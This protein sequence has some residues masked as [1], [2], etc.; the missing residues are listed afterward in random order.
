MT[1]ESLLPSV[2]LWSSPAIKRFRNEL[3][4]LFEDF[5]ADFNW[6]M[7]VFEDLQPKAGFPKINVSE[8]DDDY[9]LEIAVAG[10]DKDDVKLELKDGVLT[11][12]ADKKEEKEEK[13]E[14]RN[15]LRKEISSRSF[16]RVVK[17]PCKV[18]SDKVEAEYTNGVITATLPK[19]K[20]DDSC[21]VSIKV[22]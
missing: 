7:A 6:P 11:I 22:K 3:D 9:K 17:F 20:K 5:F 16:S 4:S 19:D 15:Y 21:G 10:F 12:S 14:D 18:D 2:R 8:T 1:K 13:D